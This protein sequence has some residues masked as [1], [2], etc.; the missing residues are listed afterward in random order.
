M[1]PF[2]TLWVLH[3]PWLDL[4][5][6]TCRTL[7]ICLWLNIPCEIW[8]IFQFLNLYT[9]GMTPSIGDQ[10][11]ARS[12]PTRRTTQTQNK[13]TIQTSMLRMGFEPTIPVFELAKTFH[14]L[15]SPATGIRRRRL[16]DHIIKRQLNQPRRPTCSIMYATS[17]L[18]RSRIRGW[19]PPISNPTI[20]NIL[21]PGN[22]SLYRRL[23][24]A[25]TTHSNSVFHPKD[26]GHVF[27]G[28][29][30]KLWFPPEINFA[31]EVQCTSWEA[32]IKILNIFYQTK[33]FQYLNLYFFFK[34]LKGDPGSHAVWGLY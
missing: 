6:Y 32:S 21:T 27:L 19:T 8:R 31:N 28:F 20:G 2:P 3:P 17:K 24:T 29:Q 33:G 1:H 16:T 26:C 5:N 7:T 4:S 14:A 30:N 12:L 10:S 11:F 13:H 9:V 15:E 22:F 34:Y 25:C 18:F 23:G